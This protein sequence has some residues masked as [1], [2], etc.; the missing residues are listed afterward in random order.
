[1]LQLSITQLLSACTL[2]A[3]NLRIHALLVCEHLLAL[4]RFALSSQCLS[5]VQY[6]VFKFD[7]AAC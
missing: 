5:S 2:L 1:M 6:A 4:G 3:P 7:S